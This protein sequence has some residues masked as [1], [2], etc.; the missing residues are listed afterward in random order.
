MSAFA[1]NLQEGSHVRQGQVIGYVGSTGLSTGS[2]VHYE[3]MINGRFIDPMKVK[4]PRG[5]VLDGP[6]LA[7]F[8]DSREKLDQ[9]LG[10]RHAVGPRGGADD[11]LDQV[12]LSAARAA[13]AR[14]PSPPLAGRRSERPC[15]PDSGA[16]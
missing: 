13:G 7:G 16:R 1:R 4:L 3:I 10:P 5:R 6:L 9:L 14:L 11:V 15:V 2:H 12:G 8:E